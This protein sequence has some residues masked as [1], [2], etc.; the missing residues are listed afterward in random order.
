MQAMNTKRLLM[1][2]RRVCAM[3]EHRFYYRTLRW[4][5]F[6]LVLLNIFVALFNLN[7]SAISGWLIAM[8]LYLVIWTEDAE[9]G[10]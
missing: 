8:L 7:Y 4:A 5:L 3:Q 1:Q 6:G 2:Y 9:R 10:L